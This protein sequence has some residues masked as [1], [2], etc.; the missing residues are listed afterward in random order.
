[1]LVTTGYMVILAAMM[2]IL[3]LPRDANQSAVLLSH[4]VCPTVS[5][6]VCL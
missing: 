6:S 2:C 1:M 3:F 4:V 5:A